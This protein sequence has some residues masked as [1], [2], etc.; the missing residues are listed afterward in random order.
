MNMPRCDRLITCLADLGLAGRNDMQQ[1][2]IFA[3]CE[4]IEVHHQDL[5]DFNVFFFE[6]VP[7]ARAKLREI[8]QEEL[9]EQFSYYDQN[10]NG[11]ME[12]PEC[13]EMLENITKNLS[14]SARQD[15]E[16]EFNRLFAALKFSDDQHMDHID[17]DRFQT[18]IRRLREVNDVVRKDLME[19]IIY[20][21]DLDEEQI[22]SFLDELLLLDESFMDQDDDGNGRLDAVEV[23]GA[24][25]ELGL[26]PSAANPTMK[27]RTEYLV[28]YSM[29]K[30][31]GCGINFS[32]FLDLI[33]QLREESK[34]NESA[35]L[36]GYFG[37]CDKDKNGWLTFP[38]VAKIFPRLGLIPRCREDQDEVKNL[39]LKVDADNSGSLDF[40]EFQELV[41]HITE[42]LR[43]GSRRREKHV[44]KQIGY[45]SRQLTEM[46]EIFHDLDEDGTGTLTIAELRRMLILLHVTMDAD[47]LTDLFDES[48]QY[49]DTNC[50]GRIDVLGFLYF[51]REIGGRHP[52]CKSL[53]PQAPDKKKA[54]EKRKDVVKEMA[55]KWEKIED[56]YFHDEG[57]VHEPT[58]KVV[59]MR[60]LLKKG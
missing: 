38:E 31:D 57:V 47:E 7:K 52:E 19:Q 29:E 35:T 13:Y 42:K 20:T 41:Q 6:V 15:V 49:S 43:S 56:E 1:K 55:N 51:V 45:T 10:N 18:L 59:R 46:R 5:I 27:Q 53:A 3:V 40:E 8:E 23:V 54:E 39:L 32:E 33:K 22:E 26:M 50:N 25:L 12:Y 48:T 37:E 30:A 44:A 2:E 11:C 21:S 58:G 24:L 9:A 14:S 34:Y 16:D 36:K 28:D 17:F 60:S 4:E